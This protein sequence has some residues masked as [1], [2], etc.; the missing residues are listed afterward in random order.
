M[1]MGRDNDVSCSYGEA[2]DMNIGTVKKLL[3]QI[4]KERSVRVDEVVIKFP[5]QSKDE[6]CIAKVRDYCDHSVIDSVQIVKLIED[7]IK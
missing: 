1:V 4:S 7:A 3:K 5:I 2:I 6:V